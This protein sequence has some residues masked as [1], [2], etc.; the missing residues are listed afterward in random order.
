MKLIRCRRSAGNDLLAKFSADLEQSIV[1][2]IE[3]GYYTKVLLGATDQ[4]SSIIPCVCRP[5]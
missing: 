1:D 5:A 4:Y 3:A 2:T